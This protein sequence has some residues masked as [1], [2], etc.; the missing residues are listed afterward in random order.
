MKLRELVDAAGVSHYGSVATALRYLE[1]RRSRD[2]KLSRLMIE[3]ETILMN[4]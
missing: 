1:Q 4:N 3:A 2:P